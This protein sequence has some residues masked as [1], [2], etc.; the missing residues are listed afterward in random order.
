M[1]KLMVYGETIFNGTSAFCDMVRKAVGQYIRTL[2]DYANEA[3]ESGKETE[4][5]EIVAGLLE[6]PIELESD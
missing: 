3:N 6:G 2:T 5:N 1:A 4:Y